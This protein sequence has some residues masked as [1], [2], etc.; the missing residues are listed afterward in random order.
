MQIWTAFEI[1][2]SFQFTYRGIGLTLYFLEINYH[3]IFL[4]VYFR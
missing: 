1:I 3:W 4:K 2:A